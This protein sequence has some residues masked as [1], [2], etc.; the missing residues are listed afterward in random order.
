VRE[1]WAELSA[2]MRILRVNAG[3]SLRQAEVASGRGRGSLS[4]IE[5]GKARPGRDI[6]EWYEATF[7]GDGV[8]VSLYSEARGIRGP[9]EGV[10][11]V[12]GQAE[13][14]DALQVESPLL[15][16]GALV[17]AGAAVVAG[18]TLVNAGTVPW[19]GRRLKRVGAVAAARLISSGPFVEV[20]DCAPGA[21][22]P[23]EVA[24]TIPF[25]AST[26]AAHWVV[27]DGSDRSCY[28]PPAVVS[29]LVTAAP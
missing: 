4:Q 14:G 2:S 26:F 1:L 15:A 19:R 20:P 28:Q 23:V 27:T 5:N 12:V 6:V 24:I 18:W 13:P 11:E 16:E 3:M 29:V 7:Q 17:R 9:R 10:R 25:L 8:L 21:R 22:V